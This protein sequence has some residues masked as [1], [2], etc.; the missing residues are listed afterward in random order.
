[1]RKEVYSKLTNKQF[2]QCQ[3]QRMN[4]GALPPKAHTGQ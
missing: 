2:I 3:N 4:H 1:V